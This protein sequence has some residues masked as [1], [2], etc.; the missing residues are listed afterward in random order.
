MEEERSLINYSRHKAKP[1][2]SPLFGTKK[3][4]GHRMCHPRVLALRSPDWKRA[5]GTFPHWET[6]DA[7]M[8]KEEIVALGWYS[9]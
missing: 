3:W 6:L 7:V 9:L 1:L 5:S 8:G 2:T 4:G